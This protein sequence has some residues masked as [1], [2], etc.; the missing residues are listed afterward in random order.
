MLQVGEERYRRTKNNRMNRG[1]RATVWHFRM[2][3]VALYLAS[4]Y[5]DLNP[6]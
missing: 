3:G 6:N 1:L 5:R 2:V 4:L